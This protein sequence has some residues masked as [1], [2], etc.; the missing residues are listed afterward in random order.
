MSVSSKVTT[1]SILAGVSSDP[2]STFLLSLIALAEKFEADVVVDP[3][4]H[5][6]AHSAGPAMRRPT[7]LPGTIA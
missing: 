6:A 2:D 5:E 3:C 7:N 4:F 1:V